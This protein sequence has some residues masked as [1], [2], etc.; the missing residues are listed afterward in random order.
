[1]KVVF[2]SRVMN[3]VIK[4]LAPLPG[5]MKVVFGYCVKNSIIKFLASLLG[6]EVEVLRSIFQL[7]RKL[8]IWT[9]L[10]FITFLEKFKEKKIVI[11]E[12]SGFN[13]CLYI[14]LTRL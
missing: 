12:G 9:F 14:E 8:L 3:S 13:A 2:G 6:I 5:T 7:K 1:M 11:T 4:L 10:L